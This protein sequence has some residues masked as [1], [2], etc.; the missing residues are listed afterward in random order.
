MPGKAENPATLTIKVFTRHRAKCP[1]RDDPQSRKCDCRKS[2]YVYETGK[3][4]YVSAKTRSWAKAEELMRKMMDERDP[5]RIALREIKEREKKKERAAAEALAA[6]QARRTAE[7]DRRVTVSASLDQWLAGL[8]PKSRSR[9]VQFRSLAAK[10]RSW[11]EEK[12]IVHLKD[13]KPAMLYEW[14]G[15]WSETSRLERDRMGP[16]TRNLYVSHLHRFFKWAV[17]AEHLDRDPSVIVKRQKY[18][19]IQTQPLTSPEQFDEIIAATYKLDENRYK[20]RP[21]PEYGRDLRAIFQLQR[22]TGL[23]LIDALLLKRSSIRAGWMTLTTK[24]TGKLIKDR[25]LP[26]QVLAALDAVPAQPHVRNGYYFWSR[27]CQADNLTTVWSGRIVALNQYFS[28]KDDEGQPMEFRSHML[29]DTFAVDLLLQGVELE[30]V[31]FLLTHDSVKMTEQ[32][33]A[34]WVEKR[35]K[36]VHD[37]LTLA[38]QKS[39][40]IFTPSNASAQQTNPGL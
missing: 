34:P 3:V 37:E 8:Q 12:G 18:E 13:V 11:A 30:K 35:R 28:L 19:R 32:Y 31:S 39:G 14:Q 38:L 7:L 21:V 25:P 16:A 4:R 24:K 23:R 2:L 15:C 1:H 22:W 40:A 6:E 29:R 20:L 26:N 5:V 33:Y 10:I 27:E 17:E 9:T 36:Q